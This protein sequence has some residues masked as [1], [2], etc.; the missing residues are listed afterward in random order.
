MGR[1]IDGNPHYFKEV[2][3]PW[4]QVQAREGNK[5]V[6]DTLATVTRLEGEIQG[7]DEQ[8]NR[9]GNACSLDKEFAKARRLVLD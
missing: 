8:R 4:V 7:K 2:I 6:A 3:L 1:V 5:T 9:E